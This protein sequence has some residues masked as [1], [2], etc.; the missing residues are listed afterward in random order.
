MTR[1][2]TNYARYFMTSAVK[3]NKS[4]HENILL[5][6]KIERKKLHIKPVIYLGLP[7]KYR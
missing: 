4:N 1:Y 5:H 7:G 2:K 3:H 6:G